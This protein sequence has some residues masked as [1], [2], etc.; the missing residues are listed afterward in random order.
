MANQ[1]LLPDAD[2]TTN[3]TTFGAGTAHWDRID[4]DVS[5]TPDDTNGVETTTLTN[6][7]RWGFQNT[8]ANT[9]LVSVVD[10]SVRCGITDASSNAYIAV[11]LYH[12]GNPGTQVGATQNIVVADLPDN[13]GTLGNVTKQW[14]GLSLTKAQADG[15]QVRVVFNNV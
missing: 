4:E 12:S 8:P 2:V 14:S 9:N 7:D 10:V 15:L 6:D 1:T 5:G 11:S 3:W 13:N